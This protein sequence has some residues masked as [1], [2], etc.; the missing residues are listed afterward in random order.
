MDKL[1]EE[2]YHGKLSASREELKE[3][4][5][6]RLT[7]HHVFM[8]KQMKSHIAYLESQIEL[9]DSEMDSKLAEYNE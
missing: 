1:V 6:G 9:I 2:C 3:A 5:T 8:L 4:L 7:D